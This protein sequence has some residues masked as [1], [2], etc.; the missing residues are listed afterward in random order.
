ML[1]RSLYIEQ[2]FTRSLKRL[3]HLL[4]ELTGTPDRLVNRKSLAAFQVILDLLCEP[5]ALFWP[6]ISLVCK[7]DHSIILFA[8]YNLP[9]TQIGLPHGVELDVVLFWDSVSGLDVGHSCFHIA[10]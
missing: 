8:G 2:K 4:K 5:F 9:C 6:L 10:A 3:T 7:Y 1:L